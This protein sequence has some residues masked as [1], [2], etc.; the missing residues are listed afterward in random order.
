[1][2]LTYC[3]SLELSTVS[4]NFRASARFQNLGH[5]APIFC[6]PNS[7]PAPTK[8][9]GVWLFLLL[10]L[11]AVPFA[12]RWCFLPHHSPNLFPTDSKSN[13]VCAPMYKINS[14]CFINTKY[15]GLA[16]WPSG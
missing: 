13:A 3:L 11:H 1:M 16:R 14:F 2:K 7:Y 6:N 4:E 12:D 9:G 10:F 8:D 5:V 15:M